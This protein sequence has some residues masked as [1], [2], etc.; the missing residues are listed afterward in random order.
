MASNFRP[1]SL[2]SLACKVLEHIIHSNIMRHLDQNSIPT[3]KQHGFCKKR[4][5]VTQL[6]ATIQG[7]ARSLRSGKDQVDV[8]LLDFSKAFDKAPHQRL[9][10]KLNYYGVRGDTL[11]WISSF[12]IHRKQQ[13]LLDGC[14]SSQLGVPGNSIRPSSI[15]S[16][17]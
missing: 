16:Q 5:T 14:N 10:Y 15:L 17:H 12:L 9:L 13:V 6:V 3:M 8:V 11:D 7:I 1:V 2:T 4:S